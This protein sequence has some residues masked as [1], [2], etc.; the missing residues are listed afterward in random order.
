MILKAS[1]RG[2]A[3]QLGAHLLKA[4]NE[5]VELHEIR[6][7][8][9]DDV[10]GAMKE[11]QAIAKGTR[12]KQFLFSVSLSPPEKANVGVDA[13]E[14]AID[15]IEE[16]NGLAGQPRIVI[17]HEKEGRRH[18]H[19]V[20]SRIDSET[21][22]AKP[23]PFFKMKLREISKALYLEHGW[24]MPHGL[25][26]SQA[27]DPRNF[28]LE[29]WQQAKRMGRDPAQLKATVQECW[30]AS[31]SAIS[32]AKALEE[33]GLYLARGDHRA[34]VA[35]TYEGEVVSVA[36]LVGKKTREITACLGDPN[37][38]RSVTE[39]RE[40]IAK[41][42]APK[43]EG[44]IREADTAKAKSLEP[45]IAKRAAMRQRHAFDR[46]QLDD[47]HR[48][49]R[50]SEGIKRHARLR[51]GIMGLWDRL[52]G[53]YG[54]IKEQNESEASDTTERDRAER[55]SLV[56]RQLVERR[57]LQSDIRIVREKHATKVQE[58]HHDLSRQRKMPEQ[59][60]LSLRRTERPR[61]ATRARG[62]ELGQ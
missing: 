42:I 20:W 49:R 24:Q 32:F 57:E 44:L 17:F 37:A 27:R 2:G 38:V 47:S 58:L 45:L 4:E 41:V 7:F 60:R 56:S 11:A 52:T 55:Q 40:H 43:L 39:T 54:K 62:P 16:K 33:R 28:S 9:A 59:A 53:R 50:A 51:T 1:Q 31:D 21:M 6:G 26:N 22:T 8:M 61:E 5:H 10:M 36:R 34:H 13:F 19:A 29:E 25:M 15:R 35:V 23:L 18:C 12:C 3:A 48:E 14:R 30:A 46:R